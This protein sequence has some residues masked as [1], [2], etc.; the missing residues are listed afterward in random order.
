[1]AEAS[2]GMDEALLDEAI[3]WNRA[4]QGDR[5]D[6]AGFTLWLE[7][8]PRHRVAY[9]QIALTGRILSEHAP[10]LRMLAAGAATSGLQSLLATHW[11][12][13]GGAIVA[14]LAVVAALTMTGAP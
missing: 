11:Y 3:G 12:W 2:I 6:W 9:D 1:M 13:A 8:D 5:A 7:A 14:A 10:R 4:L